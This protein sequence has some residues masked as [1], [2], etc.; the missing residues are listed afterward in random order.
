VEKGKKKLSLKINFENKDFC[1]EKQTGFK[2]NFS[3]HSNSFALLT[4]EK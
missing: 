2:N 1:D 3:I 4:L